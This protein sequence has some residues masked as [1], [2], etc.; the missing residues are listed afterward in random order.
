MPPP[1][2][3]VPAA[4]I[5]PRQA[6]HH[7]G[8]CVPI[9]PT[10]GGS[11]NGGT[12]CHLPPAPDVGARPKARVPRTGGPGES[13]LRD[14]GGTHVEPWSRRKR[15]PASLWSLS[16]RSES[17]PPRRA[18]LSGR[19]HDWNRDGSRKTPHPSRLRRATFPPEGG[20]LFWGDTAC[21]GA[22][23]PSCVEGRLWEPPL[24]DAFGHFAGARTVRPP[25]LGMRH[26]R[27]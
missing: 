9:G 23:P 17:D 20:R 16:G 19:S 13:G 26:F 27:P 15:H 12:M 7:R 6:R 22:A 4:P 18:E 1:A 8:V 21:A 14:S 24:R 3:F 5:L 2:G 25:S 11:T 10:R